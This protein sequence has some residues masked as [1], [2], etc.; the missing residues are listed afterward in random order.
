M[1]AIPGE[2]VQSWIDISGPFTFTIPDEADGSL[3][4]PVDLGAHFES[5]IVACAD[6]GGVQADTTIGAEVGFDAAGT[7]YTLYDQD[8]PSTEWVSTGAIATSGSMAMELTLAKGVRRLRFI[9]SKVADGA[10]VVIKVWGINR[11][12]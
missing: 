6:L 7:M 9:L 12:I 5:V 3:V 11:A 1:A 8:D 4:T 2:L 10:A